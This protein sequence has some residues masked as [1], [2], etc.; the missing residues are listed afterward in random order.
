MKGGERM[1]RPAKDAKATKKSFVV[2]I[3]STGSDAVLLGAIKAACDGI[4]DK[5]VVKRAKP[6]D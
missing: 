2:K 6:L 5:V 3:L 1:V 4:G